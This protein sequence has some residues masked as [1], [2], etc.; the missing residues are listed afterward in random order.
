MYVCMWV[1]VRVRVYTYLPEYTH[2]GT[3]NGDVPRLSARCPCACDR[4]VCCFCGCWAAGLGGRG[5]GS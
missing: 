5:E 4:A 1:G 2:L 3:R